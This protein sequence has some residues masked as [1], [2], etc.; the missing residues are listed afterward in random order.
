MKI[1][2]ICLWLL[3]V[4]FI[5]SC[6]MLYAVPLA[7]PITIQ[8]TLD[9]SG[10]PVT[11]TRDYRIRFYDASTGGTQLGGDVTGKTTI[12]DT[13][14]FS[15][16]FFPPFEIKDAKALFYELA[17]DTDAITN[18]IDADES[19][20]FSER[21]RVTHVPYAILASDSQRL[22]GVLA[23][24]YATK[25]DMAEAGNTLDDAY[26][27]GG[28][29]AG[30]I[31]NANAGPVEITGA[32]GVKVTGGK[33]T[34]SNG[35]STNI[36]LDPKTNNKDASSFIMGDG[37][38]DT[39]KFYSDR[40]DYSD[41]YRF[42]G[43][44]AV[45]YNSLGNDTININA[46][47]SN[48]LLTDPGANISLGDGTN[49]TVTIDAT[50]L[51]VSSS[52]GGAIIRLSNSLG[53]A[54]IYLDADV[55]DGAQLA[56]YHSNQKKTVDL[57]ADNA[58]LGG[59][60]SMFNTA[61]AQTVILD[62]DD[63]GAG[64]LNLY[65]QNGMN[66][67]N[68]DSS[69]GAGGGGALILRNPNN[70]RTAFIDSG[71]SSALN[72]GA[73]ALYG[74]E[75]DLGVLLYGDTANG[76]GQINVYNSGGIT[77]S[78][79]MEGA[80]TASEGSQIEMK[81]AANSVTITLDADYFDKGRIQCDDI[82]L[83]NSGAL[84]SI[85]MLGSGTSGASGGEIYLKTTSGLKT[86]SLTAMEN[87]S[88]GARLVFSSL[89]GANKIVL[90]AQGAGAAGEITLRDTT[91]NTTVDI[92]AAESD[93]DGACVFLSNSD[94]TDKI[95]LDAQGTGGAGELVLKDPTGDTTVQILAAESASDGAQMVLSHADGTPKIVLDAHGTG[96]AGTIGV[97][98]ESGDTTVQILA[99]E[100]SGQGAQ[101]ALA[102]A[103]ATQTIILDAEYGASGKGRVTCDEL[104]LTGGSD[105]SENFE[106]NSSP[107]AIRPGMVVCIDPKDEGKLILSARA[108]EKTVAGIISGAGEI[109][110]GILMSQKG[111]SVD[112]KYPVA[113]TGRAYCHCDASSG[114]IEPGD[115]L[116]TSGTPGHAMKATDHE[117]AHGAIIGKAMTSLKEGRGLVLVLVNLQ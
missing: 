97:R 115:L 26:N 105:L 50:D 94:G 107:E 31:I 21:I 20:T 109:N 41:T 114:A 44:K 104:Q 116:T 95:I 106:V 10:I 8:G 82:Q 55:S 74:N 99:A 67:V 52:G 40:T 49:N 63:S 77:P 83:R 92:Q 60:L 66:S 90:D 86:I 89:T 72:E 28:A 32:D 70:K 111:T 1:G 102:R 5:F 4:G 62:A 9:K 33:L 59:Q 101:I 117:K 30:R 22:G 68:L 15:I 93:T 12:S 35:T 91:G 64:L 87:A 7:E 16:M 71:L 100:V 58:G 61:G 112:G 3:F 48:V 17:I 110:P 79:I 18:G 14:R 36:K 24:S 85:M 53:N 88:E 57:K 84:D 19:D 54:T 69:Y 38:I 43:A 29:G 6:Q 11:G 75:E 56:M 47:S 13:G 98:D 65:D 73:V 113:L 96:E 76:G 23:A 25:T 34:V 42:G 39:I 46:E 51:S 108:Y 81:N 78:I 2:K 45:F 103:D 27:Q 80:E 37:E